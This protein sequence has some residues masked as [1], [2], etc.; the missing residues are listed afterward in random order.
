MQI[1]IPEIFAAKNLL[2]AGGRKEEAEAAYRAATAGRNGAADCVAC[3][4]CEGACPQ[5]LPIVDLL[6]KCALA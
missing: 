4:Q 5:R 2:T 3:G 1:P 6:R